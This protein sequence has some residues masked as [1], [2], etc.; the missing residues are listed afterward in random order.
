M[1]KPTRI[2][3][4]KPFTWKKRISIF[5]GT[6]GIVWLFLEPFPLF[7]IRVSIISKSG[8]LGYLGIIFFSFLITTLFEYFQRAKPLGKKIYITFTIILTES[9]TR[10]DFEAP[11]DMRIGHFINLCFHYLKTQG[12]S[13]SFL[14]NPIRDMY[15]WFLLVQKNEQFIELPNDHTF[16]EENITNGAI[17]KFRG[18]IKD[19]CKER[20][21]RLIR[22][23]EIVLSWSKNPQD[24]DLH[25]LIEQDDKSH[26]IYFQ[27]MG[28]ID[29]EPWV[30]LNDDIRNAFGPEKIK[31][32]QWLSGKYICIVHNFSKETLLSQSQ[33]II[34][35]CF[36]GNIEKFSC[37]NIGDGEWWIVFAY[38]RISGHLETINRIVDKSP[39]TINDPFL[40]HWLRTVSR[41]ESPWI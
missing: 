9:G 40:R 21:M 18:R 28:N 31:I 37:P 10:I 3:N 2:T 7:S 4:E 11:Q 5:I 24:V 36:D 20:A 12:V 6:F 33:A 16:F 8:V 35:F 14:S 41:P 23:S 15:N 13:D 27:N 34:Q 1:N 39:I 30:S 32:A 17:C 19:E 29:K 26:H 22:E 38:D 25:L